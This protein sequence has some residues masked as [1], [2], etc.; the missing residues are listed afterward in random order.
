[1]YK[2]QLIRKYLIKRR[3]A[4]VALVGVMLC[5]AMVLVVVSVMSGWLNMFLNSFHGMAGDVVITTSSLSGFPDYQEMIDRVRKEVPGVTAAVPIIHTGGLLNINN[6]D[7]ETVEVY[8]YPP[9]IGE[10]NNWQ[11]T[12]HT[13]VDQRRRELTDAIAVAKMPQVIQQLKNELANLPFAP[14]TDVNYNG[15]LNSR[16]KNPRNRPGMVVSASLVGI[17]RSKPDEA[18]DIRD[19]MYHLPT[20]LTLLPV[21]GG[22]GTDTQ[23]IIPTGYWIVDDSS[24]QI[25]ALDSKNIYI[26]FDQAQKDLRMTGRPA[27]PAQSDPPAPAL[28]AVPARCSEVEINA[29]PGV[30]LNVLRGQVEKIVDEVRGSH[31]DHFEFYRCEVMTWEQQQGSFI[32]AVK[33]E[34]VLTTALFSVISLVAVLLIFCIFYMIVIE[35]TKDIGI[36]KSVGATGGGILSMFLGYGLAIGVVGAG[37][38]FAGAYVIVHYINE[39]H[40]WLGRQMGIVVWTADTYQFEK[41][42]NTM[43]PQTVS[44]VLTVA[45]LSALTGALLPA[46][47]AAVMNPVDALRYE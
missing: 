35:K 37:L 12:L 1:M 8:G 13:S 5:T 42:P 7:I 45:V 28:P 36:I 40:A 4:W 3:I 47:K 43:Q 44:I 17:K 10:V 9:N 34:V 20:S 6:Q 25:W 31:P 33:H 23:N 11:T 18:E 19:N 2:T 39:I 27:V 26:S 16:V 30:D 29:A 46:L 38:G 14:R 22:E 41:I 32:R 24:S 21:T 15:I